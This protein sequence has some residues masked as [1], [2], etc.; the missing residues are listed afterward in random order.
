VDRGGVGMS[1]GFVGLGAGGFP[2]RGDTVAAAGAWPGHQRVGP[3]PGP[4]CRGREPG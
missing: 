2:G 1:R 4:S 3:I